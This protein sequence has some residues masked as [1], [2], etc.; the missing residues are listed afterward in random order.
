LN[1]SLNLLQRLESNRKKHPYP[2]QDGA[3][4]DY[5]PGERDTKGEK[6]AMMAQAR[7]IAA[8]RMSDML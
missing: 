1:P 3:D 4:T 6:N 7:S 5:V 8:D 2:G